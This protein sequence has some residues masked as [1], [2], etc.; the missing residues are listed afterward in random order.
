MPGTPN[1]VEKLLIDFVVQHYGALMGHDEFTEML[2]GNFGF[3]MGVMQRMAEKA[4]VQGVGRG[5]EAVK[6]WREKVEGR[7][8]T[9]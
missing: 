2:S 7:M 3:T 8:Y 6:K 9:A 5:E 1:E 4:G